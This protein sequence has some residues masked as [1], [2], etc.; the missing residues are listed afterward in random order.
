[1]QF[2]QLEITRQNV[3]VRQNFS[4]DLPR[5]L[6]DDKQLEQ[7]L[8]NIILNSLQAMP[9]GGNLYVDTAR[10]DNAVRIIITDTGLGIPSDKIEKIFVPFFTTKTK[11]TGLG[12]SIVRKIIENHGG[13]IRVQSEVGKGTTFEITLPIRSDRARILSSEVDTI[14][15]REE[16]ELLRRS[17]QREIPT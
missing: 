11:G 15:Q 16:A 8:R 5:I 2:M 3:H 1:L 10:A 13:T 4:Y 12:L 9:D 6:A 17:H 7:V 14:T